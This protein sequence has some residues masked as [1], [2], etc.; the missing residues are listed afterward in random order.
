[1]NTTWQDIRELLWLA[2]FFA[3]LFAMIG[4]VTVGGVHYEV[5][6][7]AERGV[8]FTSESVAE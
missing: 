8:E 6:C 7:N 2:L 5:D 3:L 1:M 4:G